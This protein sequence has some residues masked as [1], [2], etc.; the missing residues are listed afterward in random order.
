MHGCM[1]ATACMYICACRHVN[2]RVWMHL[3]EQVR[4]EAYVP[5]Y[6]CMFFCIHI[7]MHAHL[8]AFMCIFMLAC[9][10]VRTHTCMYVRMRACM[11]ACMHAC[12]CVCVCVCVRARACV[13]V[14][15][16]VCARAL[17]TQMHKWE[18]FFLEKPN[19][20]TS[21]SM[22]L[23]LSGNAPAYST[24]TYKASAPIGTNEDGT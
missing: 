24:P 19:G 13:C 14:C 15:V 18:H 5:T 20:T 10:D 21:Q 2:V 22:A 3:C 17:L 8:L 7:C 11:H 16:C 4:T 12:M 9:M 6:V 23:W 1:C